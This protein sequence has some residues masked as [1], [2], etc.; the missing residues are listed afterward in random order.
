M[1]IEYLK[2]RI[3][4]NGL[5]ELA[6]NYFVDEN[7]VVIQDLRNKG[8]NA[9]LGIQK[10]N[11]YTILGENSVYYS[12]LNGVKGEMSLDQFSDTLQDYGLRKGKVFTTFKYLKINDKD[13]IWLKNKKTKKQ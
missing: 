9:L 3:K 4:Q 6:G 11:L 12:T 10:K 13:S 2:K 7:S 5:R 8:H 1:K